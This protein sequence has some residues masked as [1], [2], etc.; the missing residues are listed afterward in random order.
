MPRLW[1]PQAGA[2]SKGVNQMST[3]HLSFPTSPA[4]PQ[5][6]PVTQQTYP[7]FVDTPTDAQLFGPGGFICPL[8]TSELCT[9]EEAQAV[10]NQLAALFPGKTASYFDASPTIGS[11]AFYVVYHA[12]PRRQFVFLLNGVSPG[13][14]A[15]TTNAYMWPV[16]IK[17]LML[18]SYE[19][20]NGI[21]GGV[22]YPG[23][24]IYAVSNQPGTPANNKTFQWI[25]TPQL[26]GAPSAAPIT[27][28]Q[29]QQFIAAYN[30]QATTTTPVALA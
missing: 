21:G 5:P 4:P 14:P 17:T 16:Y 11:G 20:V 9:P 19:P 15:G 23:N 25:P 6:V 13:A 28:E 3:A 1:T 2:Q 30:A 24:F 10:A 29:V 18:Q 12:D 26:V 8:S 27:L 22:G 7:P